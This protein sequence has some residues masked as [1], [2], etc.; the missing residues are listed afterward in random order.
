MEQI[1][2]TELPRSPVGNAEISRE[3]SQRIRKSTIPRK[4]PSKVPWI[5]W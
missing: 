3:F 2:K 1:S 5:D 4:T